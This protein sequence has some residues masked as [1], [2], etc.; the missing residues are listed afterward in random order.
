MDKAKVYKM[1]RDMRIKYFVPADYKE[2]TEID[3]LVKAIIDRT[4]ANEALETI[5]YKYK[6]ERIKEDKKSNEEERKKTDLLIA[7]E[8]SKS[9]ASTH[10]VISE[11]QNIDEWSFE[12]KE[13]LFQ[14]ALDNSQIRYILQDIDV[15]TFYKK[16]L[17][18]VK[19]IKSPMQEVKDIIESGD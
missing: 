3:F 1:M 17:K 13:I 12:E 2:E 6:L 15:K 14:I 5:H 16:L 19:T 8:N 11:L 18:S 7:L 4:A 9:F 10:T